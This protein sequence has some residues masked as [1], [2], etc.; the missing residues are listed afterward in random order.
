[1]NW[2]DVVVLVIVAISAVSGLRRGAALQL[3]S[4]GGF[5][6][7]L[8][9]GAVLTPLVAS[10]VSTHTAKAVIALVL[11]L[12]CAFI[13]GTV[14]SVIG[15]RSGAALRRVKLGPVDSGLGVGVAVVATLLVVWL[16]GSLIGDSRFSSLASA[17]E[18][19]RIVRALDN[20]MPPP[21][22]V[23][24]KI[25]TFLDQQGFPVVFSGLPPAIAGFV[26]LPGKS[27]VDQAVNAAGPS[28]VKIVGEACGLTQEG[29]GFVVAPDLVL[30]NAHVVAG[31]AAPE[32]SDSSGPH[33]AVAVVYDPVLDVAVLRVQGRPLT[34]A[35]LK[36]DP[37]LVGRNQV[38]AVLGFPGG[39]SFTYGPAGVMAAFQATGLDIYG[40]V[41]TTRS[42]YE[43]DAVV[44]PGNSGGPL[45]EPDGEVIG[46]VFARS[47][48]NGNV[49]YA[50]AT[51]PI[52]KRVDQ[53]E[54]SGASVSTE[55]CTSG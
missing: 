55:G 43:I 3:F 45:V 1:V 29:S 17:M 54:K 2:V 30:T 24:A 39:G 28:T 38:A 41:Q 32:V 27:A 37:D 19:S 47:T 20:V 22:T 49:G 15:M 46:V 21:P 36:L 8:F 40:N 5:W 9:L 42:I 18:G 44:R 11:V 13:L 10:H 26:P 12:G 4:Y 25:E 52:I 48:V 6:G 51:P 23:L 7:G 14:G 53:A 35:P 33:P 31:V 50:L 34:G 16:A